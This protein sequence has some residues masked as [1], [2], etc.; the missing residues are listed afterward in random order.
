M[1]ADPKYVKHATGEMEPVW[2]RIGGANYK[3]QELSA[4]DAAQL[5]E[6]EGAVIVEI[7]AT[8]YAFMVDAFERFNAERAEFDPLGTPIRGPLW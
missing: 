6:P 2:A 3:H 7:S 5:D 4:K 8:L 1:K